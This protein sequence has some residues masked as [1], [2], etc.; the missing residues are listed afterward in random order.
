M[1]THG[2]PFTSRK[3]PFT[4]FS[5]FSLLYSSFT[6]NTFIGN[7]ILF[8]ARSPLGFCFSHIMTVVK[9]LVRTT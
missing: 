4:I 3:N 7:S 5:N 6:A 9:P 1:K 2:F 8:I